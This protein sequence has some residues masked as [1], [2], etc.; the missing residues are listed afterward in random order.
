MTWFRRA[1][2]NPVTLNEQPSAIA[3]LTAAIGPSVGMH[4]SE[5]KNGG[6]ILIVDGAIHSAHSYGWKL[7]E[8]MADVMATRYSK[9]FVRPEHAKDV[10][11]PDV[12]GDDPVPV[13]N[14]PE[15]DRAAGV[16]GPYAP[17]RPS[18][19]RPSDGGTMEHLR[20]TALRSAQAIVIAL[21]IGGTAIWRGA[22]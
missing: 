17:A 5:C 14:D 10:T 19:R 22:A 11:Y 8:A 4:V 13:E 15:L 9:P 6:F 1:R 7:S 2:R 21:V 16:A 18:M 20:R 12:L 3:A